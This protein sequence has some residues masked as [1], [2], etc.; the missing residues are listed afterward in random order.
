MIV[1]YEKI[2]YKQIGQEQTAYIKG[3]YIGINARYIM[4]IL[5]NC[6]N[7]NKEGFRL[8]RMDNGC[9]YRKV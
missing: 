3:R 6:E 7:N 9:S 1:D 4:D 2:N 5:N 8:S